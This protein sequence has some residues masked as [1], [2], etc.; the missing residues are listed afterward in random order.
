M[1]RIGEWAK[2]STGAIGL[3][4]LH[5]LF[6]VICA[7]KIERRQNLNSEQQLP[8]R[9][10]CLS[11]HDHLHVI[12]VVD[13]NHLTTSLGL[14]V[15][16]KQLLQEAPLF[17]AKGLRRNIVALKLRKLLDVQLSHLHELGHV[18]LSHLSGALV[19][20]LEGVT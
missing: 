9:G 2:I 19:K 10:P 3:P 11:V 8:L 18:P 16:L 13:T 15:H 4:Y 20:P 7:V 6:H 14:I 12:E 5:Q 1:Q 17:L